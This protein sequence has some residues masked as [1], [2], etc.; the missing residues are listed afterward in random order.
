MTYT[1]GNLPVG[2]TASVAFVTAPF[3]GG[4]ASP[5]VVTNTVSVAANEETLNP[6][7]STAWSTT[8]VD[9]IHPAILTGS[10]QSGSFQLTIT[11]QPGLSYV[12]QASTDLSTW[13]PIATNAANLNGVLTLTS[14]SGF[15]YR[16]FRTRLV[17]P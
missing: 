13:V 14:S 1:F 4:V 17:T 6:A 10:L 8:A 15:P 5:T 12:I 7:H 3:P 9:P 11:A 2:G 16:F